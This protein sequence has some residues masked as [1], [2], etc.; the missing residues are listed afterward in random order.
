MTF[1]CVIRFAFCMLC[2]K[3]C[4]YNIIVTTLSCVNIRLSHFFFSTEFVIRT[5]FTV[6]YIIY[7]YILCIRGKIVYFNI[8]KT[9]RS[10]I[11]KFSARVKRIN[12]NSF[13]IHPCV[14]GIVRR[15]PGEHKIISFFFFY[16]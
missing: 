14:R 15:P 4:P 12:A 9:I 2:S 16:I 7:I 10:P 3:F 8:S 11:D 6:I 1:Y 5:L 13:G